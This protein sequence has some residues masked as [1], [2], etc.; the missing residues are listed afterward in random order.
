MVKV[1]Y[2]EM[3]GGWCVIFMPHALAKDEDC[4]LLSVHKEEKLAARYATQFNT[5]LQ[6]AFA[7]YMQE[8]SSQ[9]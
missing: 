4:M 2:L 7:R 6:T 9:D 8:A 3:E 5:T 1:T